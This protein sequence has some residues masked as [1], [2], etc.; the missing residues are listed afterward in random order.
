MPIK[1]FL[2]MHDA[3]AIIPHYAWEHALFVIQNDWPELY[4]HL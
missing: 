3:L 1:E 4:S 2:R